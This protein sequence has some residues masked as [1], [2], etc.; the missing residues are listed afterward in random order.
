MMCC[1]NLKLVFVD[2]NVSKSQ[3]FTFIFMSEYT[4]TFKNKFG[5]LSQLNKY[6]FRG[7]CIDSK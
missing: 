5:N 6:T 2:V 1:N 4:V 7:F 3:Y